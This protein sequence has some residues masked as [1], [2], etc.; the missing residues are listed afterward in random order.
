ME[1][2]IDTLVRHEPR[3]VLEWLLSWESSGEDWSSGTQGY[4]FGSW[5][6]WQ[7]GKERL[8]NLSALTGAKDPYIRVAGAVYLCFEDCELGMAALRDLMQIEGDPGAWAA[9]TLARRGD[10]RA[11]PR[12]LQVFESAG[13]ADMRGVPHQNLQKRLL[14]LLSNSTKASGVPWPER[15]IDIR[16]WWRQNAEKI[17]LVDPWFETLEKQK[18]D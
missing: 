18:V 14:V 3:C 8:R 15:G 13:D 17:R 1:T 4:C 6:A 2:A 16:T 11:M 12:A 7:C 10:A 9:L 5:F